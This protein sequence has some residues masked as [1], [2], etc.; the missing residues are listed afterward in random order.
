MYK[1]YRKHLRSEC[2]VTRYKKLVNPNE[3]EVK[4]VVAEKTKEN[5]RNTHKG[6]TQIEAGV[7]TTLFKA[8]DPSEEKEEEKEED[9]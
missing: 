5:I 8:E 9:A 1:N 6:Y 2:S 4:E 3:A 7:L